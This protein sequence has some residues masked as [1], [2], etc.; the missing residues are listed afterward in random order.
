MRQVQ[1][2]GDGIF[3]RNDADASFRVHNKSARWFSFGSLSGSVDAPVL[4]ERGRR[5]LRHQDER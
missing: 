3:R 5:R 4:P 1:W 2:L